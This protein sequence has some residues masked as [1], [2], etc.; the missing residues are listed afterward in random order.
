[1]KKSKYSIPNFFIRS[2]LCLGAYLTFIIILRK[3]SINFHFEYANTF[4]AHNL[5]LSAILFLLCSDVIVNYPSYYG[6]A[7]RR[8]RKYWPFRLVGILF[9]AIIVLPYADIEFMVPIFSKMIL[10]FFSFDF[11]VSTQKFSFDFENLRNLTGMYYGCILN[12]IFC[13]FVLSAITE[14]FRN[15]TRKSTLK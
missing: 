8:M 3:L 15:Q 10:E 14:F 12:I 9:V 2:H 6:E 4:L 13:I 11:S 7:L 5:G 1:M